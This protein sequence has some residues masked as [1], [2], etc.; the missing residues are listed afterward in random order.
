MTGAASQTL[1]ARVTKLAAEVRSLSEEAA[2]AER[3]AQELQ[4]Q[5][6]PL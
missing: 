4:Q 6:R 5:V 2:A 3:S 1:Q